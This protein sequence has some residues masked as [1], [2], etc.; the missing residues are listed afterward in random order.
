MVVYKK[1]TIGEYFDNQSIL[2]FD[3]MA[4]FQKINKNIGKTSK[5]LEVFYKEMVFCIQERISLMDI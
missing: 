5:I 2:L 3:F 1:I 4:V